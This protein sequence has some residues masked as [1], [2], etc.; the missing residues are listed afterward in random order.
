MDQDLTDRATPTRRACLK[1]GGALLAGGLLAG[2]AG[3]N[4]AESSTDA[5]ETAATTAATDAETAADGD[6]AGYTVSMSRPAT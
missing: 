2:C 6:A 5:T 3:Q 4:D 1:G